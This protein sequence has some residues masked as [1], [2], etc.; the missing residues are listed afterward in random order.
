MC[1]RNKKRLELIRG[2]EQHEFKKLCGTTE[3]FPSQNW[4][5]K[6]ITL[7]F[8]CIFYKIFQELGNSYIL[9]VCFSNKWRQCI[10]F[11]FFGVYDAWNTRASSS[12]HH[13]AINSYSKRSSE[14]KLLSSVSKVANITCRHSRNSSF[15][16]DITIFQMT[17]IAYMKRLKVSINVTDIS[18]L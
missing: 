15:E 14:K 4:A 17:A 12:L 10:F 7:Y 18:Y 13:R 5:N 1:L 11:D 8:N 6:V 16:L 2:L 9:S 3:N